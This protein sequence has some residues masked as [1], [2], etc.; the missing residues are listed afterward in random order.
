[1]NLFVEVSQDDEDQLISAVSI[2]QEAVL[3]GN[4]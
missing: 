2:D 4:Y 1:M 3:L